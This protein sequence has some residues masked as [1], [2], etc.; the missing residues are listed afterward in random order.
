MVVPH[1]EENQIA[2]E[3]SSRKDL[4]HIDSLYYNGNV[5]EISLKSYFENRN[6]RFIELFWSSKLSVG[7]Y[8]ESAE[9]TKD[10]GQLC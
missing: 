7:C 1:W 6:G 9:E 10:G 8:F 3:L 2:L 4:S 5:V